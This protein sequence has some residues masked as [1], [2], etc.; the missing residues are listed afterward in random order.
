MPISQSEPDSQ[1]V[2][3]L[4]SVRAQSRSRC[5]WSG[6]RSQQPAAWLFHRRSS[7]HRSGHG[8]SRTPD[9]VPSGLERAERHGGITRR[10]TASWEEERFR[11]CLAK[12]WKY[13]ALAPIVRSGRSCS[14]RWCGPLS[15]SELKRMLR[16]IEALGAGQLRPFAPLLRL[17]REV[18]NS[19][20][21]AC[22]RSDLVEAKSLL[23]FGP[24]SGSNFT[25]L[26]G[27]SRSL[28]KS[29]DSFM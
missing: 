12:K 8:R 7:C 24:F 21:M 27:P 22:Y 3:R 6:K 17:G 5:I 1:R 25:R 10:P 29:S 14:R 18:V 16:P 15:R 13:P 9:Y 11:R 20:V 28:R 19:A 26:G 2:R 23:P 4:S